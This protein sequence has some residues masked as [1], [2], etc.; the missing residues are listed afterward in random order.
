MYQP[1][2]VAIVPEA[3]VTSATFRPVVGENPIASVVV[4]A[5]T[6]PAVNPMLIAGNLA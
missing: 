3:T 1:P 6:Q 4:K 5:A 2:I